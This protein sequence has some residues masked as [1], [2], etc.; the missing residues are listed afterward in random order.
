MGFFTP[1]EFLTNYSN[2]GVNKAKLSIGRIFILGILAGAFIA[3]ASTC[4]N[5][6]S[7]NVTA[8][9]LAR[10][11]SAIMFPFGLCMVVLLGAELFTG[12]CLMIISVL[13]RQI[14]VG[15]MIRNWVVAYIGNFVGS[16]LV[17]AGCAFAGQFSYSAAG[18]AAVTIKTAAAKCSLGFGSAIVLG[19]MCN[20][21]VCIAV[22]H[23]FSA[24]DVAGKILGIFLP[25]CFFVLAG[26]E[27]SIAN[28]YYIP[29]GLF[30]LVNDTY[31]EAAI[32][33]GVDLSMLTWGNCLIRNLLP[34]TIGNII[35][36]CGIGVLMWFGHGKNKK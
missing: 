21:L 24:K 12:N 1:S 17:A 34:V 32:A 30:A 15:Q 2:A 19:I 36:G 26:F 31:R 9:G 3:F 13:D 10:L 25:V 22:L 5:M 4:A 8:A 16:L 23:A 11:L 6:A 7:H 27:H 14:T 29:A 20:A 28:M 18:L 33:A 35:G